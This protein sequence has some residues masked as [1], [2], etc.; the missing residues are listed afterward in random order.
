MSVAELRLAWT[1]GHL[2]ACANCRSFQQDMLA[3]SEG[4]EELTIPR[5]MGMHAPVRIGNVRSRMLTLAAAMLAMLLVG[6]VGAFLYGSF[7]EKEDAGGPG[8]REAVI[9]TLGEEGSKKQKRTTATGENH[10][11]PTAVGK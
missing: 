9:Y 7:V 3:L 2:T 1:D 11:E 10:R 5:P 8:T 4:L 6:A